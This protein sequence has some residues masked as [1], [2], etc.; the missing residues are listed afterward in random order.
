M[1]Y[2][3]DWHVN[4]NC[5]KTW[6]GLHKISHVSAQELLPLCC[7]SWETL[8]FLAIQKIIPSEQ[9]FMGNLKLTE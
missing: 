9:K 5:H 2:Y 6:M 4:S 3:C 1:Q 8:A 7:N